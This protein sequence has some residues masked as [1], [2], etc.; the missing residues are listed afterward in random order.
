M[1]EPLKIL[2]IEARYYEDI[3][4]NLAKGA[5]H[6]IE[7]GGFSHERVSVPGIFEIPAAINFALLAMEIQ[8]APAHYAGFIALGCV[9]RGETDHYEHIARETSRALMDIAVNSNIA[10]GFGIL[11]CDTIKQASVRSVPE[12]TDRRN[13]GAEAA[14][15]CLRMIE[16]KKVFRLSPQ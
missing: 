5:I 8:S 16:L 2:I 3:A 9:I 12:V 15:A 1:A 6:V 13:K 11:T 7:K 14:Q 10:F 4:D